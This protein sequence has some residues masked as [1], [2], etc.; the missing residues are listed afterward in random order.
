VIAVLGGLG[1]ALMWAGTTLCSSRSTRMI[2]PR[3]VLSWVMIVG[4]LIVVPWV[5]ALGIPDD[6]DAVSG[7]WLFVSGAGNVVGLL[8]TYAALRIGK[9]GV[10][11]PIVSTE[12]AIA[13]VI[14]VAMGEHLGAGAGSMLILIAVGIVL[15]GVARDPQPAI[16]APR[17]LDAILLAAAAAGCFGIGLYATGHVSADLPI[18]WALLPARLIGL[19]AVAAPLAL[20]SGLRLTRPALPLVVAGGICEVAGFACYAV[21]ARHGIAVSAVLASQF[22]GI[23][24]LVGFALFRERLARIQV[25]GVTAIV[26]GVAVL[27]GIQSA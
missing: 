8:L 2:G 20:L 15:A 27:S 14:A 22:G 11:A 6:L 3:S 1:A 5:V 10:V 25:V 9:V 16:D 21:G 18:A 13:A 26:V 12:G 24:A 17:E 23:A 4:S 7:A 19:V